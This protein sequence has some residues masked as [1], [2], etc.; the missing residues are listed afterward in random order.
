MKISR[1]QLFPCACFGIGITVG[2]DGKLWAVE[3]LGVADGEAK[4]TVDRISKNGT[5]IKRY[6]I[7]APPFSDQHLPAW[8]AAGD[9]LDALRSGGLR[10]N[11][12]QALNVLVSLATMVAVVVALA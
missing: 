7:P 11:R 4:G 9:L 3:E 2:P 5:D 10:Q 1:P 12:T 6:G 8:D